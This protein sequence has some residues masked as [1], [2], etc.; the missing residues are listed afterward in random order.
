[1]EKTVSI[2]KKSQRQQIHVGLS[3]YAKDGETFN[4]VFARV[5]YDDGAEYRPGRN[6]INVRVELLPELIAALQ[7]AEG[8]ARSAGLLKDDEADSSAAPA[9]TE[10]APDSPGEGD[11]TILGSG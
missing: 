11:L 6:G 2:I 1:M 10:T 9:A 5:F 8:A 7:Q 3:E 4:M